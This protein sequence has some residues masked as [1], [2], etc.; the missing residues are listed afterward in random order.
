MEIKIEVFIKAPE[1]VIAI[2]NLASALLN[3]KA[4]SSTDTEKIAH[5]EN[6]AVETST[7]V[8]APSV[9]V[10]PAPQYTIDQIMKAGAALMDAGKMNELRALIKTFKVEAVTNLKPEQL[11]AFATELRK[12]GAQI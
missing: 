9:P 12:L 3:R 2:N 6:R 4:L 7:T 5:T 1:L 8:S 10:A 11:G